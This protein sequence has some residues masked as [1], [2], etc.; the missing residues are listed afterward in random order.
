MSSFHR[1]GTAL[2]LLL[3]RYGIRLRKSLGQHVLVDEQVYDLIVREAEIRQG[4]RVLEVGG[5]AGILTERLAR[6]GGDLVTVELDE[7]F[8]EILK[9]RLSGLPVRVVQGDILKLPISEISGLVGVSHL[10]GEE[11]RAEP[12]LPFSWKAVGNLPYNISSAVLRKFFQE[13]Q[14]FS[15]FLF[16]LQREVAERVVAPPGGKI[17]GALSVFTALYTEASIVRVIS[18]RSFWPVPEVDSALVRF[19]VRREIG[20]ADEEWFARI[21]KLAFSQRRKTIRNNLLALFSPGEVDGALHDLG[22]DPRRRGETLSL[23]DFMALS[24]RL[25]SLQV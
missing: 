13:R 1:P 16:M 22:I 15:L 21:V 3:N 7:R 25:K 8:V 18:K 2:R 19:R 9:E 17:Y 23:Y 12:S 4:E 14:W 5:G 24:D 6:E 20:T 11:K 10:P